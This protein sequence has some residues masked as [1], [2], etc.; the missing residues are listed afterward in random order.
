M[1]K[2]KII[3]ILILMRVKHWIKNGLIFLP[4]LFSGFFFD[5]GRLCNAFYAFLSFSFLCSLVYIINDI[6]DV[7]KDRLHFKKKKRPLASGAI[8]IKMSKIIVL[9]LLLLVGVMTCFLENLMS[10]GILVIYLVINLVYSF[11]G[12]N[13]PILDVLI[14]VSGFILRIGYGALETDIEISH[15]FYLTI[16]S[17]SFY[18]ALGK[19]KNELKNGISTRAVLKYYNQKYLENNMYMFLALSITFYSL[20]C[21]EVSNSGKIF[22]PVFIM[23]IPYVICTVMK[24]SLL[25][26]GDIDGDPIETLFSDKFLVIA[27]CGYVIISFIGIYV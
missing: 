4:L 7:E 23:T 8:S 22:A 6:K 27:V 19:R 10:I 11:G 5:R 20:W 26:E 12:K 16:M 17:I 2:D 1:T 15:W 14:L 3:Q 9:M 24:Y 25:L 13:I 18:L 21:V